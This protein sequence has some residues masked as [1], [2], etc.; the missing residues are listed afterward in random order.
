MQALATCVMI[1]LMYVLYM[2]VAIHYYVQKM[3]RIYL[4]K[5]ETLDDKVEDLLRIG[6][7][8]T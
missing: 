3:L 5:E 7:V 4:G 1:K 6:G 2:H 8:Y